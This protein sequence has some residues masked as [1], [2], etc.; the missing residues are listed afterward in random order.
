MSSPNDYA[1]NYGEPYG[2]P[3]MGSMLARNREL[4]NTGKFSDLTIKCHGESFKVHKAVVCPCSPFFMK[5][6]DGKFQEAASG[7]ITLDD[8]H[9]ETV[10]R[11]ISFFYTLDYDNGIRIPSYTGASILGD[12]KIG[13][14]STEQLES[15]LSCCGVREYVIA[16]KY[17]IKDLK[18]LAQS[19]FSTWVKS[20]WNHPEFYSVVNEV[21]SSTLS[22]DRGLRDLVEGIV[23]KNATGILDNDNFREMLTAEMGEL[24]IAVL[25]G[26]LSAFIVLCERVDRS[27]IDSTEWFTSAIPMRKDKGWYSPR[28]PSSKESEVHLHEN[29]KHTEGKGKGRE[30]RR[31]KE[32]ADRKGRR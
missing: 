28:R 16:E 30:K 10:K 12:T 31:E 27:G 13:S 6:C 2:E 23:I 5:A 9:P 4:L 1:T 22:N 7:V 25:S 17:D 21:Y 18:A 19:R 20:N 32:H 14:A 29:T 15:V 11:M 24:G 3:D 8:D 26:I